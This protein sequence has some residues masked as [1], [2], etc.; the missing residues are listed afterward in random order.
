MNEAI[1]L[2]QN[3]AGVILSFHCRDENGDPIDLSKKAV[4]FFLYDDDTLIN[5]GRTACTKPDSALGVAEYTITKEDTIST[6]LFQGKLRLM[7]GPCDVR[8]IGSI[9]ILIKT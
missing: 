9:P 2:N 7:G 6:G 5:N 1:Q 4:D 3:D 8:N